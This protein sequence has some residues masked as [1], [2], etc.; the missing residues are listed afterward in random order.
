MVDGPPGEIA[1]GE[2]IE[3]LEA[4]RARMTR[5]VRN[6]DFPCEE[7]VWSRS[8]QRVQVLV[9]DRTVFYAVATGAGSYNVEIRSPGAAPRLVTVQLR[10]DACFQAADISQDLLIVGEIDVMSDGPRLKMHLLSIKTGKPHPAAAAP[11]IDVECERATESPVQIFREKVV[12][13]RCQSDPQAERD[14]EVWNWQTCELVW[15]HAFRP[16]VSYLFF[17]D[18]HLIVT[19]YRQEAVMIY[20]LCE[21]GAAS[22]NGDAKPLLTL[23]LPLGAFRCAVHYDD[24]SRIHRSSAI[25]GLPF[26]PDPAL[27]VTAIRFSIYAP[28]L[29]MALLLIPGATFYEQL[30]IGRAENGPQ[31]RKVFWHEWAPKGALLLNM[32]SPLLVGRISFN[33]YGSR[34]ALI[35][36]KTSLLYRK[37]SLEVVVLDLCSR[38]VQAVINSRQLKGRNTHRTMSSDDASLLQFSTLRATTSHVFSVGPGLHCPDRHCPT[39]ISMDDDGFIVMNEWEPPYQQRSGFGYQAFTYKMRGG[40]IS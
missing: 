40:G 16:Q 22:A 21:Q 14:V 4:H 13:Q 38:A 12:W 28:E 19:A 20:A 17:D 2:R 31:S 23:E 18:N 39:M 27:A 10:E 6:T 34:I 11:W 3:R 32:S 30:R 37:V 1:L 24:R 7:H 36:Q 26:V 8:E 35:T 33:T 29:S 25:G 15:R 9:C 5:L